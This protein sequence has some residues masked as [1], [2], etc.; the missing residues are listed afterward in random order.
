MDERSGGSAGPAVPLP[1]RPMRTSL[2]AALLGTLIAAAAH[3]QA[4]VE[5]DVLWS[6]DTGG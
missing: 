2:N 1:R 3:G 4:P 5:P 6:W